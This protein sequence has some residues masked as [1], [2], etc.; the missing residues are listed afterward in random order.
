MILQQTLSSREK[1]FATVAVL[2]LVVLVAFGYVKTIST[3]LQASILHASEIEKKNVA[4]FE[5]LTTE[6]NDIHD[7]IGYIK[8]LEIKAKI[9]SIKACIVDAQKSMA[10]GKKD[11]FR[12]CEIQLDELEHA[13]R[14][15]DD[16]V[17]KLE[18]HMQT[19]ERKVNEY[20]VIVNETLDALKTK[21]SA[22]VKSA[23]H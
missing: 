8:S 17:I 3:P 18:T 2:F 4:H 23:G 12:D 20:G 5:E 9:R 19:L 13:L 22:T 1:G 11:A 21:E 10:S 7:D 6:F 16:V 15:H 14:L